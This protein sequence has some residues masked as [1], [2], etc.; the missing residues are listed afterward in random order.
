MT[1]LKIIARN[2]I[3]ANRASTSF[4]QTRFSIGY[5]RTQKVLDELEVLGVLSAP[6]NNNSRQILAAIDDLDTIFKD[7]KPATSPNIQP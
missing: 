6:D 7:Y 2:I 4:I 5:G 1:D 3:E